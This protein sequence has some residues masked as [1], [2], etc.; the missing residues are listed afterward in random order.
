MPLC[1][2]KAEGV[3]FQ[4]IHVHRLEA[5]LVEEAPQIRHVEDA[6]QHKF[7]LKRQVK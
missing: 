3:T 7:L 4:V 1:A 5:L 6:L 2:N